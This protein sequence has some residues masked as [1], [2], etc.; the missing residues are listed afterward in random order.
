MGPRTLPVAGDRDSAG[1]LASGVLPA[2]ARPR[3][4]ADGRGTESRA[5]LHAS[6][7]SGLAFARSAHSWEN[8]S[9]DRACSQGRDRTS[10]CHL[11]VAWP[12]AERALAGV[13]A[14]QAPLP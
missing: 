2:A 1:T 8:T 9:A 3:A 11:S 4:Q 5:C 13:L 14:C 10:A 6:L 7:G 12:A